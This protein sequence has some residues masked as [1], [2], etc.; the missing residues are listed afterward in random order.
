MGQ[1][2]TRMRYLLTFS[3]WLSTSLHA[4]DGKLI[5]TYLNMPKHGLAVVVQTPGGKTWM[6]DTGP[7]SDDYDAGRDTIAPFLKARDITKLDGIAISHPHG[8]HYGGSRWLVENIPVTTFVDTG[9][10]ARGFSLTYNRIRQIAQERGANYIAATE[11]DTLDFDPALTVEV[12][13]PPKA[14][15][16]TDTDPAKI[17]EHGLLN[18]NSLFLRMT[19]GKNVI[20]FPGDAYG[21]GQRYVLEKT[22][23]YLRY[24]FVLHI[25]KT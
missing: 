25:A 4:A 18:T 2:E 22:G 10:A 14:M 3:L 19:H 16:N 24:S 7:Q 12:L 1:A 20:F 8:D 9:Y 6:I 15:H 23:R 17:T 5:I 21:T 13:S 11:G